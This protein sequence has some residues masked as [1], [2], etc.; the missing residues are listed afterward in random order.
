MLDLRNLKPFRPT[1]DESKFRELVLYICQKCGDEDGAI[2]RDNLCWILFN[3]DMAAYREMGQP[4]TGAS[5][6]RGET[7]PEPFEA[8]E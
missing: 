5:Y 3:V 1:F 7:C 8:K 2:E 4:I 6:Y